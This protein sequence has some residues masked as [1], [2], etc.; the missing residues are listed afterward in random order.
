MNI[1]PLQRDYNLSDSELA[2]FADDLITFMTRGATEFAAG[3]LHH[4]TS[5]DSGIRAGT[6]A[7]G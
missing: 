5:A 2:L 7:Y 1:R 3:F 4:P 6:L